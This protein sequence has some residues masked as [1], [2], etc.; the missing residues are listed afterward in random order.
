MI[1][2]KQIAKCVLDTEIRALT[3]MRD[4]LLSDP[5]FDRAVELLLSRRGAIVVTGMGK[6]GHIAR[7]IAST[8]SS[9]GSRAFFLHP[10]EASHGDMS[11]I[12]QDEIVI[13]ISNSGESRELSDILGYVKRFNIPLISITRAA[14]STLAR[15]AT[16]SIVM[17]SVQEC[18]TIGKAPTTSMVQTL[19]LGDVLTV[20]LETA[21]NITPDM[22]LNWHPGGK[23]GA[24]LVRVA[25]LMHRRDELPLVSEDDDFAK[26]VEV[27]GRP[28][29]FGCVGVVNA[30]GMLTG[31]FTDG[32]IRRGVLGGLA[33]RK[34]RE[35]MKMNPVTIGSDTLA[36]EALRLLNEKKIQTLF[37]IDSDKQPIGIISFHDLLRAGIM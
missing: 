29:R 16:V 5:E 27:M 20:I 15:A 9:T 19:G 12:S 11:I 18:C 30:A 14:E 35:I 13:A 24:S 7:K 31:V 25:D 6:S 22:Y 33:G 26:A 37:V 3:E 23:L 36:P 21:N 17:P 8:M 4:V 32:D 28:V 1:N 34:M 2:H 10:G